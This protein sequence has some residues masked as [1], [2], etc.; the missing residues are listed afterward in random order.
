[1]AC[2]GLWLHDCDLLSLPY[3]ETDHLDRFYNHKFRIDCLPRLIEYL[4]KT[5]CESG[6]EDIVGDLLDR[7]Q[8]RDIYQVISMLPKIDLRMTISGSLP[9]VDMK[10][11]PLDALN[12]NRFYDLYEDE[13]YVINLD[14]TRI[15][16]GKRQ[17]NIKAYAPKYPKAKDEN[18]IIILGSNTKNELSNDLVGL[19]RVNNFKIR[20]NVNISFKSPKLTDLQEGSNQFDLTLFFMSDVYIGLD[21]QF[22]FKFKIN[23]KSS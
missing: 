10:T 22:E 6:L 19:K 1:M 2:Q 23:K 4:D 15:N 21:Q 7:N 9:K 17:Q 11:M 8:L 12:E 20:Q 18:W 5:N 14:I 3:I 16:K 13:D